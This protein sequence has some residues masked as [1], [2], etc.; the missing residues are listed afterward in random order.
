MK[1]SAP[2]P[3]GPTL[4]RQIQAIQRDP[5]SFLL[6]CAQDYGAVVQFPIGNLAVFAVNDPAAVRHVLQDNHRNYSKDT[7]QFNT[8]AL[9]TGRGLLTSDG[10]VWL[11]Q[12]RMM[13]PA[14]HRQRL[15]DFGAAMTAAAERRR[16]LW[17][18]HPA[19]APLDVD[20]EMMA[21]ALE[22]VGHT[23]FSTDLSA[24]AG[25]L[26]RAV[27]TALD[28]IVYR[29]QTPLA[30]PLWAPTPRHQRFQAALRQLDQA[31]QQLVAE[32]R[33]A[34]AAGA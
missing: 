32:R 4:L 15:A 3:S 16:A 2:G 21:L 10:E 1:P 6:G 22:V 27:L 12:R 33:A 18:A 34:L 20:A 28:F 5:L 17:A 31:V 30:L 24:Q 23:L 26:V 8:L 19:G 9:V 14:F 7:I 11:R 25:G 13:Q 29:A